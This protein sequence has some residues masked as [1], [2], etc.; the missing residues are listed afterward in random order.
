MSALK[1]PLQERFGIATPR[2]ACLD[3]SKGALRL[4]LLLTSYADGYT[5]IA[6]PGQDRLADELGWS[7]PDGSADRRRVYRHLQQLVKADLIRKAGQHSLGG[8]RWVR[9]Y[10]VAPF[11]IDGVND[12]QE[13]DASLNEVDGNDA[14]DVDASMTPLSLSEVDARA[15]IEATMRHFGFKDAHV[16]PP[17]DAH[18]VDAPSHQSLLQ[19]SSLLHTSSA[20]I[21]ERLRDED[22]RT[23][24]EKRALQH[25]DPAFAAALEEERQRKAGAD[26]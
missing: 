5:R 7:K 17:K 11:P 15:A 22:Q 13:G 16:S 3:L 10:L 20:R 4:Y 21:R 19:R 2:A 6:R 12:T 18:I 9:K 23:V 25:E 14:R 8:K 26:A 24:E 1:S